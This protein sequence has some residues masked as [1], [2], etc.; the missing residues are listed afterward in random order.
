MI[1]ER[2]DSMDNEH[3]KRTKLIRNIEDMVEDAFPDLLHQPN[4]VFT[5]LHDNIEARMHYQIEQERREYLLEQ[6]ALDLQK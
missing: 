3:E 4:F 2:N 5:R 6:K 1:I